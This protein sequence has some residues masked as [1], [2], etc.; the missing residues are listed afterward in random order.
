MISTSEY[1]FP[2]FVSSTDYNLKDLRAELARYLTELGYRP[3]LSSAEGF[4]DNSP[5]LEPWE[6]CLQVLNTCFVM[7]LVIDGRYGSPLEWRNFERVLGSRKI[8][9]THAEYIYSHKFNKRM[10]VFIREEVLT[11][12][13]TYRTA[14]KNLETEEAAKEA[15]EK[16]LPKGIDFETLKFVNEVKTSRPIPWIRAFKDVTEIKGE[17]QKKM[18]NELAELFMLKEKKLETI[19]K[20]FNQTMAELSPEKQNEILKK[21]NAVKD[22]TE[23][24][25][26]LEAKEKELSI[27]LK[28]LESV[29]KGRKKEKEEKEHIVSE[30]KEQIENL[31]EKIN[32]SDINSLKITKSDDGNI[33][34]SKDWLNSD[35]SGFI[36]FGSR[37]GSFFDLQ[38][39]ITNA[40][41]CANCSKLINS[42]ISLATF[43][44]GHCNTCGKDYCDTCWPKFQRMTTGGDCPWCSPPI[45]LKNNKVI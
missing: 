40:R 3:V 23:I 24:K 31:K 14:L 16:V 42:G 11:H 35:P 7:I 19:I 26:N 28:E 8:S 45:S 25:E 13:Q 12:Y 15:L 43:N 33:R 41:T 18:L 2:I 6:S 10:L 21:I 36:P 32:S 39:P 34:I 44:D 22:L 4:H 1:P 37:L 29:K 38:N 30:L 5:E 17:V 27:A 9:P 20:V